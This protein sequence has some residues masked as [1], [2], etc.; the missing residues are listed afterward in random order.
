MNLKEQKIVMVRLKNKIELCHKAIEKEKEVF[1]S[2]NGEDAVS[3]IFNT[4][5]QF[6]DFF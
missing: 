6:T 5:N 1:V 3:F 4:Q 2:D